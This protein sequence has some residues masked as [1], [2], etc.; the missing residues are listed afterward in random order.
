MP[1]PPAEPSALHSDPGGRQL[2]RVGVPRHHDLPGGEVRQG[3]VAVPEGPPE[4]GRRE[5]AAVL[6]PG[7]AVPAVRGLLLPA[8]LRQAAGQRRQREEDAGRVGLFEHV[9]WG[10]EVRRRGSVDHCRSDHSGD[11]FDVRRGQG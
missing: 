8:D 6:R 3:R 9:P 2:P 5:P 10:F 1:T 11:G 7:Y 4:A